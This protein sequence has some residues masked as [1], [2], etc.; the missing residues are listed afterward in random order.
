MPCVSR[1]KDSMLGS[2]SDPQ[3]PAEPGSGYYYLTTAA[4]DD[5]QRMDGARFRA[6]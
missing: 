2:T 3:W 5:A 6:S 1:S 4:Q